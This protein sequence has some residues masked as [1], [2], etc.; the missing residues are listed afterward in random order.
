MFDISA[1]AA[2]LIIIV[3]LLI[4]LLLGV[5]VGAS[6]GL[7]GFGGML[8]F[9]GPKQALNSLTVVLLSTPINFTLVSIPL[10]ILMAEIINFSGMVKIVF[11]AMERFFG[12]FA[13]GM[14]MAAVGAG[15]IF[16]AVTGSSSAS[17]ATIG[18]LSLTE[19]I[20]R[21]VDKRLAVGSIAAAGGLAIIIPPST[22]FILYG[23]AAD[24][25]V[26]RLFI[27][28]I[29]PGFLMALG[30]LLDIF[31]WTRPRGSG[32]TARPQSYRLKTRILSL[33]PIWPIGLLIAGI[34]AVMYR[35]IATPTEAAGIGTLGA[36][37]I[38]FA[39]HTF[40]FR[41]LYDALMVT[42]EMS[43]FIFTIIIGAFIFGFLLTFL[44][45]PHVLA[46]IVVA[47]GLPPLAILL[48][49]N[50]LFLF[51]GAFL[52]GSAIVLIMVPIV[53]PV[54][55][56]VGYD[57]IWLGIVLCIN[58][59][60]GL[61]TPPVGMNLFVLQGVGKSFGI[62]FSDV[63]RGAAP[64]LISD[65]VVLVLVIFFPQIAMWLPSTM[66]L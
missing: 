35:G 29:I 50:V 62:T 57:P 7:V 52:N 42:A 15:T 36:F 31:I 63:V 1:W 12:G 5:P 54:L 17:C 13:G 45:V 22:L 9:V 59:E 40:S 30:Y 64:F 3:S 37:I 60:I 58:L 34:W 20:D 32:T 11:G 10:F 33:L 55:T 46:E 6:L 14:P 23:F 61:T 19:M 18:P 26:V 38:T 56:Q 2:L 25:S 24:V 27:G 51:L 66:R 28:G 49:A 65:T 41:K 39:R 21:K 43:G 8:I 47:S 48:L 4:L 44:R 16:A 53:V